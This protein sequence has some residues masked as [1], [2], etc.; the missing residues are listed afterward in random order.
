MS[1]D[2]YFYAYTMDPW[3]PVVVVKVLGLFILLVLIVLLTIWAER[4]V[5][6]RMQMRIGP[7]RRGPFG[8]LQGL[9][10]GIIEVKDR[11]TGE[12]TEVPSGEALERI[13]AACRKAGKVAGLYCANAER[14]VACAKRACELT[15]HE[16]PILVGTLAAAYAE[17]GRFDDAIAT[18]QRAHALAS[19]QGNAE[20]AQRN[21]ALLELYREAM[22]AYWA[23]LVSTYPI[24]SIEDGMAEDDW[25]GWALLTSTLGERVQLGVADRLLAAQRRAVAGAAGA[26]VVGREHTDDHSTDFSAI[27]K[28]AGVEG[29]L[30]NN[31]F[32]G[33][34]CIFEGEQG[35]LTALDKTPD[36]FKNHDMI[37]VR[38]ADDI[39]VGFAYATVYRGRFAYRLSGAQ[40]CER[41]VAE[42]LDLT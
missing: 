3:W 37:I 19:A 28:L 33:R 17:A 31:I 14:A 2:D 18:A 7:N 27:L 9:A 40:D 36:R 26:R 12:R 10:D 32:R 22:V 1:S 30:E 39:V 11:L 5:V 23:R 20:L 38:Y 15:R 42:T 35:L 24:V 16:V 13:V 21:L 29:G 41:Q 34:A 4:R 25:D 8:L 6:A